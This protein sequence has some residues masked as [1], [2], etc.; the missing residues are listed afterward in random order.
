MGSARN[1]TYRF[2]DKDCKTG[3]ILISMP[4]GAEKAMKKE[5]FQVFLI[6]EPGL[7]HAVGSLAS[8]R[9]ALVYVLG[10]PTAGAWRYDGVTSGKR[11]EVVGGDA[12]SRCN[13]ACKP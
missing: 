9:Q 8:M 10:E 7:G 1:Q 3:I 6:D 12:S 5:G 11:S 2:F 13:R 4:N